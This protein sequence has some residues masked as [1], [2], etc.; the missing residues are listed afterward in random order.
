[1]INIPHKHTTEWDYKG[2]ENE[3]HYL[4]NPY[5]QKDWNQTLLTKLNLM[6]MYINKASF[7]GGGNRVRCNKQT[8][9]LL[10]TLESY[11]HSENDS[12]IANRYR[13]IVDDLILDNSIYVY[14]YRIHE[15]PFLIPNINLSDNSFE[16]PN[17][18]FDMQKALRELSFKVETDETKEEGD[19]HRCNLVGKIKILDYES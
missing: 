6:S 18:D 12:N 2:W 7:R 15:K 4:H 10:K 1:M 9:E 16:T 14:T 17:G 13:V 3:L 11:N 19:K 5:T 8:V